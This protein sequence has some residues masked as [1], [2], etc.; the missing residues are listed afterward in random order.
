MG[1]APLD[2]LRGSGP[3]PP[4]DA[5]LASEARFEDRVVEIRDV[6]RTSEFLGE[7]HR[8]VRARVRSKGIRGGKNRVLRP[9]RDNGLLAPVRPAAMPGETGATA[10]GSRRTPQTNSGARTRPGSIP[11]RLVLVLRRGGSMC[12]EVA[13]WHVAKKGDR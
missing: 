9:M 4:A 11:R 8:K 6:L 1:G 13:G 5:H 12:H 3:G 10:N 2:D 7:G